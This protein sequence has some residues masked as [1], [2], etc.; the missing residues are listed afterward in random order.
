MPRILLSICALGLVWVSPSAQAQVYRCGESRLYTDKPC[1]GASAVDV[2]PNMLDAGTRRIPADPP[3]APAV[4]PK[5]SND[6]PRLGQSPSSI[7]DSRDARDAESRA[8]TAPYR[9]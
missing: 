3:P 5:T 2:R 9:P 8:R 4:I 6:A 1:E 7:W